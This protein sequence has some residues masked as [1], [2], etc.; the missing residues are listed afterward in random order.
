[1]SKRVKALLERD[2]RNRLEG[3][4]SCVVVN[5][6]GMTGPQ[7][8]EI[9]RRF[10]ERGV[11][12]MVVK[13]SLARRALR[14]GPL[15]PATTLL[16]GPS[17]ICWGG[18]DVV[19]LARAVKENAGDDSPLTIR[20]AS[21]EGRQLT[22]QDVLDLA[23]LPTRSEML[24]GIALRALSPARRVVALAVGPVQRVLAQ[25]RTLAEEGKE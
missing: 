24:A 10:R 23:N 11:R 2:I 20:G 22:A 13:N 7:S 19:E 18:T 15:E 9:R 3:A 4:S 5:F 16:E 8:T 14:G 21:V 12:M 1:M 25:I 17:A 6:H